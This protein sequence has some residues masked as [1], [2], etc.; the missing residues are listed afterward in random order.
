MGLATLAELPLEELQ[1][2]HPVLNSNA[3]YEILSAESSA[4]SRNSFGGTA[5]DQVRRQVSYW[6]KR[7]EVE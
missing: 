5:P 6:K 2:L 7:L 3:V 4:S 1:A